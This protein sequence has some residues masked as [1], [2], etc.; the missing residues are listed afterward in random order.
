MYKLVLPEIRPHPI[1]LLLLLQPDEKKKRSPSKDL[2]FQNVS[3]RASPTA[4]TGLPIE[5]PPSTTP[6]VLNVRGVKT[7]ALN[8]ARDARNVKTLDRLNNRRAIRVLRNNAQRVEQRFNRK[9][10]ACPQLSPSCLEAISHRSPWGLKQPQDL[11]SCLMVLILDSSPTWQSKRSIKGHAAVSFLR[12]LFST[13]GKDSTL[14]H[15]DWKSTLEFVRNPK[16]NCVSAGNCSDQKRS[17][18]NFPLLPQPHTRKSLLIGVS[19]GKRSAPSLSPT[20]YN[21]YPP[22]PPRY[23]KYRVNK[24]GQRDYVAARRHQEPAPRH[25]F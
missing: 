19:S 12:E 21:N 5:R 9:H 4:L 8:L 10:T 18:A 13:P 14:N 3:I 7:T 20:P 22:P 23:S 16:E 24:T 17:R 1:N 6:S 15:P 2:C 11:S 25:P